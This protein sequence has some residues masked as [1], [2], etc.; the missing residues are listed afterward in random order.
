MGGWALKI[1]PN[2]LE[3]FFIFF[4]F[5]VN[6]FIVETKSSLRTIGRVRSLVLW[7]ENKIKTKK[8]PS[9]SPPLPMKNPYAANPETRVEKRMQ[10]K[11][12]RKIEKKEIEREKNKNKSKN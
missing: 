11:K 4:L 9:S 10:K 12:K 7:V 8:K 1:T 3:V 6:F 2:V 5:F